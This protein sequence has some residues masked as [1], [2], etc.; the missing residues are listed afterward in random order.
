MIRLGNAPRGFEPGSTHERDQ[1]AAPA[2]LG[3]QLLLPRH[4]ARDAVG[5]MVV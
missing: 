4:T 1:D 2:E 5:A 3:V